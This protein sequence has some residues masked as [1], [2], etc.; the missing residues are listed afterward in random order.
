MQP[1]SIRF[2]RMVTSISNVILP[3]E[4]AGDIQNVDI[5]DPGVASRRKGYVRAVESSYSGQVA[6][7]RKFKDADGTEAV[8]VIGPNGIEREA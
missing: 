4:M 3:L 1:V 8:I 6:M 5:A 7:V 2:G